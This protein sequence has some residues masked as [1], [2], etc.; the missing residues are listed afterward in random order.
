MATA[1]YIARKILSGFQRHYTL[2]TALTDRAANAF[3]E[4]DWTQMQRLSRERISYYDQRVAEC[5]TALREE[6]DGAPVISLWRH[7]R[8]LYSE[9][10]QFHPQ[11]DL[12][13]TFY[14]SVFC[15]LFHHR[16]FH[17][18]FIFVENVISNQA[19]LP[20]AVAYRSYF[21][22]TSSV[23]GV[24]R[25][26]IHDL[27]FASRFA[28]LED[29][30]DRLL[31]AF[32]RQTRLEPLALHEFRLDILKQPFYRNKAAYV[33][34]RVLTNKQSIPFIVPVLRNKAGK[35]YAD[36]LLTQTRHLQRIFS[37]ARAYF[38]VRCETPSAWV[39][40]L[41]DL[42]PQKSRSELYS[43][44]GFHKQG[45]TEFYRQWLEHLQQTEDQLV[46]APGIRGLV[47]LV[48]TLPSFPYVFKVIRDEFGSTK[49]ITRQT[50]I[51]RYQL[52]KKHDRVGRMADTLEY[53]DVCLP[54]S[55]VSADLLDTMQASISQSFYIED[56]QLIIRHL[57]VERRLTPL[58]LYLDYA[59]E[60][61][62]Q[63]VIGE[64]G[65]ALKDMLAADIFPGDM[66]LK[67]FGV[68]RSG[69]V[70]FYD[71][72]EV[73]Y[74]NDVTFCC[75]PAEQGVNEAPENIS[76]GPDD[77]FV[78]QLPSFVFHASRHRDIFQ[79]LHP[80]LADPS[81][82][83]SVQRRVQAGEINDIFPYPDS[84]RFSHY[85]SGE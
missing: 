1:A 25:T 19:P 59:S 5:V 66:L 50:V 77:I 2:F 55:R 40:F 7:V 80:E 16:Y 6:Y 36:A 74:L 20:A 56:E 67:N 33:I 75:L 48:F 51:D 44:L 29:D 14:N 85:T 62:A 31:D 13:A 3:I 30:I 38:M 52:V 83:Q 27:G 43:A 68:T 69:R 64:Y 49:N 24:L 57:F 35:L 39:S 71:Y 61:E 26:V 76:A 70:V 37:F 65:Q 84:C 21:P 22:V 12:A 11:A 41:A 79:T 54:L 73:Q 9:L 42:L 45:K 17:N 34:G 53:S 81:Y 23:A 58:N 82:W 78:E 4:G 46:E 10:L 28:S 8:E 60:E 47:M 15:S 63:S 72:D 18:E 32:T